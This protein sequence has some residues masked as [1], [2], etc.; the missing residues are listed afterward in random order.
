MCIMKIVMACQLAA[1]ASDSCQ[2]PSRE[3]E[4]QKRGKKQGG[5]KIQSIDLKIKL[6]TLNSSKLLLKSSMQVR[7]NGLKSICE[8][9]LV[10]A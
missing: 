7:S 6:R 2:N 1:S 8:K 10:V 9:I 5:S 4:F 3:L